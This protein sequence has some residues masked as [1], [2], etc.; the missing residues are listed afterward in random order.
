MSSDQNQNQLRARVL[1][2]VWTLAAIA[3]ALYVGFIVRA[4]LR[5]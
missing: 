1:R 5:S 2:T 3:A 4:V